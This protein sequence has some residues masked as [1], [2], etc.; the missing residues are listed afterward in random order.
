MLE[1]GDW[2][3]AT[4]LGPTAVSSTPS[5]QGSATDPRQAALKEGSGCSGQADDEQVHSGAEGRWSCLNLEREALY[6]NLHKR[7]TG[8]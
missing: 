1:T 6:W 4:S 2:I 7:E 3:P 8:E 5:K